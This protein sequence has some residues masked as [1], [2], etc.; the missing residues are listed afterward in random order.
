MGGS[1]L[2]QQLCWKVAT[3]LQVKY[4]SSDFQESHLPP[5]PARWVALLTSQDLWE[6]ALSLSLHFSRSPW[7]MGGN[8]GGQLMNILGL[9]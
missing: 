1:V 5:P 4:L 7:R 3:N 2:P 8:F 9:L 6:D